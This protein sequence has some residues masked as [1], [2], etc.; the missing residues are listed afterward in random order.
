MRTISEMAYWAFA[1]AIPYP[2]TYKRNTVSKSR[3]IIQRGTVTYNDDALSVGERFSRFVDGSFGDCAFHL[4][5]SGDWSIDSTEEHVRQGPVHR[6]TLQ[7]SA[8]I[9]YAGWDWSIP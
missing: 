1:T 4:V 7:L 2:T 8:S 3:D 6:N 9:W 5:F